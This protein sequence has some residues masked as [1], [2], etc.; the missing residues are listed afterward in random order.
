LTIFVDENISVF[1][2]QVLIIV[3]NAI[4]ST[5]PSLTFS[6]DYFQRATDFNKCINGPIDFS[7]SVGSGDLNA[8]AGLSLRN[9]WVAKADDID[10][11]GWS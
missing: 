4:F 11:T 3:I 1:L 9:H 8:D 5:G 7:F 10:A 6:L 2:R